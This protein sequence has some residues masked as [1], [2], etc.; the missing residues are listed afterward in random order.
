M[1]ILQGQELGGNAMN[2]AEGVIAVGIAEAARRLG[3]SART[4]ATLVK[5][6]DLESRKVGRRR[7]IP[8]SVLTEFIR[9]DHRSSHIG[10][11]T[12][13]VGSKSNPE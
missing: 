4:I 12:T 8:I 7:L 6:G 1:A 10:P 5:R 3:L 11:G 13:I 9:R 2:Q